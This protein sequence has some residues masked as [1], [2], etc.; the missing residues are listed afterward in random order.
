MCQASLLCVPHSLPSPE[1]LPRQDSRA[2]GFIVA[3]CASQDD[4]LPLFSTLLPS[5]LSLSFFFILFLQHNK[6]THTNTPSS[7]NAHQVHSC[8]RHGGRSP[9]HPVLYGG[10]LE[11]D[12]ILFPLPLRLAG[13]LAPVQ[14][15]V[16]WRGPRLGQCA[17]KLMNCRRDAGR[18]PARSSGERPSRAITVCLCDGGNRRDSADNLI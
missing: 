3:L 9:L 1:A 13:W 12:P 2:R 18:Q 8:T 15:G 6:H 11:G 14:R 16:R 7:S 10:F 17:Q 5:M 4:A